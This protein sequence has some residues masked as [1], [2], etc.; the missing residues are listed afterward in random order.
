M[1]I[2]KPD[3][4]L[5]IVSGNHGQQTGRML[6]A[7]QTVLIIEKPDWA[8]V[9]GDTNSTLAGAL[10]AVK[11]SIPIA[12]IEVGLRS[13]NR[14]MPEEINRVLTDHSSDLLFAPTEA[15]VNNLKKE[16]ID[17][18]KIRLVGDVMYDAALFYGEESDRQCPNCW[19]F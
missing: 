17:T 18:N 16:G 12:H 8:L 1:E 5:G 7:I 4:H 11:R 2:P 9:Y 15:A 13:F 10:A 3:Y 14:Q 6:E 19:I